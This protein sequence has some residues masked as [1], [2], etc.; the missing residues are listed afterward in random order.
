MQGLIRNHYYKI[1][2]NL[3]ILLIFIFLTGIA[4][5]IFGGRKEMPLFVFLCI[6]IIGLPF[7]SSIDLRKNNSDKWNQYI[8][9]LPVKRCE[10]VKS[11]FVTQGITILIGS[12][13][14][15]ILFLTSFVIYGFA[16][17]RY[18]DVVLLFSSAIG[19]SLI[20]NAIFLPISYSDS[21]DRTEAM[22]IISLIISVTIMLGLIA[23]TNILLEKPT[24][25]QLMIFAIGNLLLAVTAFL[26]SCFLTVNIYSK[27]DC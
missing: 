6:T 15:V 22:S 19:I 27:Q 18:V 17:Y 23:L 7:I 5:L 2:S 10:I 13:L 8:L 1:V 11:V 24:E 3:K 26:I 16:F 14:S 20:M 12:M 25:M 4:I 21:N 9:S